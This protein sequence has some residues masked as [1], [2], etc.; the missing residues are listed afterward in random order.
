MNLQKS[1]LFTAT[2]LD[3]V[4]DHACA[5]GGFVR[6]CTDSGRT[7]SLSHYH[8]TC[9]YLRDLCRTLSSLEKQYNEPFNSFG[10]SLRLSSDS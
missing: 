1:P 8:G 2:G 3:T 6:M 10:L 4:I 7:F 9:R 5:F